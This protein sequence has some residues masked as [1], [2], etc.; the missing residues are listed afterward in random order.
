MSER[1]R[2]A[3]EI[4]EFEST[5]GLPSHIPMLVPMDRPAV[6]YVYRIYEDRD[7]PWNIVR[8]DVHLSTSS[9]A[10][11]KMSAAFR[12]C[13]ANEADC[14]Y[15]SCKDPWGLETCPHLRTASSRCEPVNVLH[16][17][18]ST[19]FRRCDADIV[20]SHACLFVVSR[21]IFCMIPL[22]VT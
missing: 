20:H 15:L 14:A 18:S 1:R 7:D 13:R 6:F 9:R 10:S 3:C 11:T 4:N 19:E 5:R 16:L 22:S 17:V 12:T 21:M 8:G 2:A